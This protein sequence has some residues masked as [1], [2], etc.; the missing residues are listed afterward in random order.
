MIS[1]GNLLIYI[2]TLSLSNHSFLI[3]DNDL[4]S[5]ATVE[6]ILASHFCKLYE[7]ETFPLQLSC[8]K[9]ELYNLLIM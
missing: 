6:M 2:L 9:N 1:H 7:P 8:V 5:I 4:K 3:P